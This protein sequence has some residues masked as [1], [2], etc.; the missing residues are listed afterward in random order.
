MIISRSPVL[1]M[2]NFPNKSCIGNQNT[3]IISS[4]M[5]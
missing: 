4:D 5:N 2:R 1:G 3:S